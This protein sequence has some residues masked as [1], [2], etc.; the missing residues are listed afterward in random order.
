MKQILN[1]KYRV[2]RQI[3]SLH[4][5]P[6]SV[7]PLLHSGTPLHPRECRIDSTMARRHGE[8]ARDRSFT[9]INRCEDLRLSG[10]EELAPLVALATWE[11]V[12]AAD[13][14]PAPQKFFFEGLEPLRLFRAVIGP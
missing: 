1:S 13:A 3:G 2:N 8:Y 6:R 4:L 14:L 7:A 5:W 9:L 10:P 11:S 12:G